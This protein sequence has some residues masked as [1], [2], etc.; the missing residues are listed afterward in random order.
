MDLLNRAVKNGAK[1]VACSLISHVGAGSNP[2][3][4]FGALVSR[5]SK[6]YSIYN[7]TI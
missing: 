6:R 5:S 4:L 1:S 3:D 2:H 7:G